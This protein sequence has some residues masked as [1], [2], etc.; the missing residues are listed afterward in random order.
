MALGRAR[1]VAVRVAELLSR[2]H[3]QSQVLTAVAIV[4]VDDNGDSLSDMEEETPPTKRSRLVYPRGKYRESA[5]WQMLQAEGL[6]DHTTKEAR[7]FRRRFRVPYVFF[8]DL[9]T[10][11]KVKKW[12]S[13]AEVDVAGRECI[14]VEPKVG[15]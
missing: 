11:V 9:V 8:V 5:W 13:T 15:A 10:L 2:Q 6:K 7:P 3:L 12:F 4:M 1:K 14:P